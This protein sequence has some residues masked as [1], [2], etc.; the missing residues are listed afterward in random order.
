[1]KEFMVRALLHAEALGDESAGQAARL[2]GA[3][4]ANPVLA[5]LLVVQ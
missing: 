3:G 2:V 4:I 1:M 5:E